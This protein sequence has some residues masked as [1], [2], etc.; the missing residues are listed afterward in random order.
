MSFPFPLNGSNGGDASLPNPNGPRHPPYTSSG[1]ADDIFHHMLQG[2]DFIQQT[3]SRFDHVVSELKGRTHALVKQ[4]IQVADRVETSW[5]RYVIDQ[6]AQISAMESLQGIKDL[7]A[8]SKQN[9][10]YQ[11]LGIDPFREGDVAQFESS[12]KERLNSYQESLLNVCQT[13]GFQSIKKG[14]SAIYGS[15]WKSYF[16]DEAVA[17]IEDY[18]MIFIPIGYSVCQIEEVSSD[19]FVVHLLDTSEHQEIQALRVLENGLPFFR[20]FRFFQAVSGIEEVHGAELNVPVTYEDG[21]QEVLVFKG[22]FNSDPI[23]LDNEIDLVR[24]KRRIL[25]REVNKFDDVPKT[26]REAYLAQ[27]PVRDIILKN[28]KEIAAELEKDYHFL[29]STEGKILPGFILQF[30]KST[31]D[32]QVK[33][34]SLML[35]EKDP[36]MALFLYDLV[37]KEA[38]EFIKVIR[39]SLHFSL[40]RKLDLGIEE[41][42]ETKKKLKQIKGDAIPLETRITMSKMDDHTKQKALEKL[43]SVKSNNSESDKAE[44]YLEGLLKVPFG[45]YTPEP[46]TRASPPEEIKRYLE[47]VINDLNQSVHSHDKAKEAVMEWIAQRISNGESKGECIALEGPPGNGK[48]TFAREGIAKALGRPFAFISMGGQ[49]D[50]S[51]LIGHG[52]TYVGSDWGRIVEILR[53]KQC[54]DPVIYIDEVDKVSQTEKG[55]ELIGVLTALTDFSQNKEFQDKYFSGIK[56]DLSRALFVFSYNDPSKLDPVFKDRLHIIKTD[57]LS[58]Q[59]KL[60]VTRR[61]L[62]PEILK[63]CGFNEGDILIDDAEIK[64]LI[65]QYTFEAGA[66]KLKEN[67]FSIVRGLNKNRLTDPDSISLPYCIDR[68]TIIRFRDQPKIEYKKIIDHPVVGMVNGLYATGTGIGGITIVQ[69]FKTLGKEKLELILTGSQGDVMKESMTV[70]RSVAWNLISEETRKK[71][72]E[73]LPEALH[74]HAPEGATPK[75]G[76]SAGGAITLAIVS[77]LTGIPIRNDVAMTGEIDLTGRISKIGGLQAKLHGAKRAG[78]RLALV[79]RDNEKDLEKIKEKFPEL[80]DG[81]F[82]VI[83]VDTIH[84]I[85][86]HALVQNPIPRPPGFATLALKPPSEKVEIKEEEE[87]VKKNE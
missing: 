54:M 29:K 35:L 77:Q 84:D 40:Q 17:A 46:V 20:E 86:D 57:P 34:F 47:K 9:M 42:E 43:K 23:N 50:S 6:K 48:T 1:R 87:N 28:P 81:S 75:D 30:A 68:E 3:R 79:P 18:S 24:K 78:V 33:L 36:R 39:T 71:I 14:L 10:E 7:V 61:H 49:T 59:D 32:R 41:L 31:F 51:F 83:I 67:L 44:K 27:Y 26:F 5:R 70:A 65:E 21:A 80:L 85:M 11:A 56:F 58:T 15:E 73:G 2:N 4:L 38:P 53:E 25:E 64:Y 62:L 74:I 22:Y 37:L 45:V 66:R 13:V 19:P 12:F 8:L 52:F 69:A 76:P 55:R 82:D 16:S 63:S 72:Y 60:I